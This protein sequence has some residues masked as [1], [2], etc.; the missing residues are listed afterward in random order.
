[1]VNFPAPGFVFRMIGKEG[2]GTRNNFNK[3]IHTDGEIGSIEERGLGASE[4]GT[5]FGQLLIPTGS[6]ADGVDPQGCE[7]AN[8][9][10]SSGRN[11]ELH[12]DAGAAKGL[13][14]K[15]GDVRTRE[16]GAHIE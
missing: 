4:F 5:N 2:S 8:I 10:G 1:M 3:T 13:A 12:S 16:A 14:R 9:G 11:G 7:F 6:A 15:R